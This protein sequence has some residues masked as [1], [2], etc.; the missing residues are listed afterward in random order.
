VWRSR[1]RRRLTIVCWSHGPPTEVYP[2]MCSLPPGDAN[3]PQPDQHA[4]RFCPYTAGL[5]FAQGGSQLRYRTPVLLPTTTALLP[6]YY[7]IIGPATAT[8]V[9]AFTS[10][11]L[12]LRLSEAGAAKHQNS[13]LAQFGLTRRPNPSVGRVFC[14]TQSSRPAVFPAAEVRVFVRRLHRGP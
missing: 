6:S 3:R 8:G 11:P 2:E 12:R 5:R 9:R 14:I 10:F 7:P 1:W 13:T 4:G